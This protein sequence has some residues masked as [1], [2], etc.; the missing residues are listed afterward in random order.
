MRRSRR[1]ASRSSRNLL[2]ILRA[3]AA[4]S[5]EERTA[6]VREGLALEYADLASA[7]GDDSALGDWLYEE[8][9]WSTPAARAA[10][11]SGRYAWQGKELL[12]LLFAYPSSAR[13]GPLARLIGRHAVPAALLTRGRL[14]RPGPREVQR[15]THGGPNGPA[16]VQNRSKSEC[17]A[18]AIGRLPADG[19]RQ[20]P[21]GL[22]RFA[23]RL[24]QIWT[25]IAHASL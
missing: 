25:E 9:R 1:R 23:R 14:C 19:L 18:P 12:D 17:A 16:M 22:V 11:D 6:L 2:G 7:Q 4:G 20:E 3:A 8:L 21:V 24:D 15:R 10:R 13:I 5:P